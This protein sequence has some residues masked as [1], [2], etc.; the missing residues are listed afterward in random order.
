[1]HLSVSH[2][3]THLAVVFA[4]VPVGVD[5][6]AKDCDRPAVAARFFTKQ[7]KIEPFS[8][9]WT[10]REAVGKL[11]GGGLSHALGCHIIQS[12]GYWQKKRYALIRFD[13]D[14][15]V[16]TIALPASLSASDVP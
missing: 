4:S 3:S 8:H 12:E 14:D 10:A 7:E 13:Q 9:I 1:M 5:V 11:T 15:Q 16:V 2:S 6:E